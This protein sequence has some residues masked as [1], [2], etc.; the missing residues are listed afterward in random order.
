MMKMSDLVGKKVYMMLEEKAKKDF[1][2]WNIFTSKIGCWVT[3]IDYELGIWI[4]GDSFDFTFS[5][6]K[7]GNPIPIANRKEEKAEVDIFL[8]WRYIKGIL[9]IKDDRAKVTKDKREIGFRP[10][11]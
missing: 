11:D 5:I 6:D 9:D 7:K 8:Q 10:I 4:R 3:G 1:A 2:D